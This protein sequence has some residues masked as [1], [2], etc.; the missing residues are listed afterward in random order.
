[1]PE[2][3]S[4]SVSSVPPVPADTVESTVKM[5]EEQITGVLP[6]Y[7]LKMRPLGVDASSASLL[8]QIYS[9]LPDPSTGMALVEEYLNGPFHRGWHVS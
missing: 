5:F 3:A 6:G 9:L 8:D 7:R 2:T 4:L 1:V